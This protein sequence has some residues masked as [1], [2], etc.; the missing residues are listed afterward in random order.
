MKKILFTVAALGL[1]VGLTATA[2]SAASFSATGKVNFTGIYVSD[3]ADGT[4]GLTANLDGTSTSE[5]NDA[6]HQSFYLYP[7]VDVNDNINV[8][9]EFRFIDR[10][11]Y[12]DTSLDTMKVYKLWMEYMSPVGTWKLGRQLAGPW[13][14]QF[15]DSTGT[16]D[17]IIWVPNFMPENMG[18]TLLWQKSDENDYM[19]STTDAGDTA[20]WYAGL[21]IKH[22][23]G[24]TGLAFNHN[25]YDEDN[26]DYD[27]TQLRYMGNYNFGAINLS[28]EVL[29][30]MGD[31]SAGADV[32]SLNAYAVV[33]T[34]FD[35]ITAGIITWYAQGDMTSDGDNEGFTSRNGTGND[36]NPFLIATGD[37]FGVLN[38]D[39]GGYLAAA[40]MPSGA[41]GNGD[42][43]GSIALALFGVLQASDKMSFNG[44]IGQV[45]ADDVP[46]GVDDAMGLEIDLGMTYKLLDNLSY[47]A[48]FGYLQAGDMI[49]D[50]FLS[51]NDIYVLLHSLTMTF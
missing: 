17:R 9:G 21:T 37:Y 24:T 15:M 51:T 35:T 41:T 27:Q 47:T 2:A 49:D 19:D 1:A 28:T 46:A 43:P 36:F 42:N 29:Y 40:G 26:G 11:I 38:G 5:A 12:G 20:A 50:L 14:T 22:E 30:D 23:G 33:S 8:K 6:V 48:Q 10:E 7:T 45:W 32:G 34:Q 44:A 13:G 25:R 39:K 4:S 18:L 3:G 16:A 31:D